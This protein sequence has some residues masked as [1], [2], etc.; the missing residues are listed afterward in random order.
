MQK[1]G[2]AKQRRRDGG[3]E[4]GGRFGGEKGREVEQEQM[5]LAGSLM[6]CEW[7]QSGELDLF[8][9]GLRDQRGTDSGLGFVEQ[10]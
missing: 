10:G 4:I 9:A 7:E 3:L 5:L 2:I 8:K 1:R 6:M